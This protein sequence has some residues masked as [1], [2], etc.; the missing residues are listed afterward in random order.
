MCVLHIVVY[1]Y[2]YVISNTVSILIYNKMHTV[3]SYTNLYY[4]LLYIY[5]VIGREFIYLTFASLFA[6]VPD[7]IWQ[8]KPATRVHRVITA[9]QYSSGTIVKNDANDHLWNYLKHNHNTRQANS[10]RYSIQYGVI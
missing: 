8:F 7:F 6:A 1:M 9:K 3:Y 5:T 2:I 10:R 4:T